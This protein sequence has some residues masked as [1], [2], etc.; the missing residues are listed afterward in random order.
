MSICESGLD[1]KV[2]SRSITIEVKENHPLVHLAQEIPWRLLFALVFP[3]L[4]KTAKGMFWTGRKLYVRTHIA[5]YLLQKMTD[6]KDRQMEW[7]LRDNAAYQIFCGAEIVG[8]WH[9]PDHTKIEEFRSRLSPETQK[10]IANLMAKNG[11]ILG[12]GDP[13]KM[14]VDSTI[15]EANLSYPSDANLL[16]KLSVMGSKVYKYLI[17]K[18][19]NEKSDFDLKG[20]K[21]KARAYFFSL[22]KK[23]EEK[24]MRFEA[25]YWS[26][27]FQIIKV[28][29]LSITTVCL[30]GMPWNIRRAATQIMEH[31]KKFLADAK[32]FVDTGKRISSK[33]LSFHLKEIVCF[34]KGKAGKGLQFGRNIQLGRIGGNF[35]IV[36]GSTS[37]R[38]EDKSS[39]KPMIVEHQRLFGEETLESF[40]TDKGYYKKANQDYLDSL[41]SL[42][43]SALQKPGMDPLSLPEVERET[44][45]KL[46]DRRA[47]IEPLIGHIKQ[48][49]QLGRSR[50]KTDQTTLA[51]GYG[52]VAGFNLRQT[53]RHQI[54]K[55]I[56]AM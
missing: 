53:M 16:V 1:S 12:F 2:E 40:G 7:D 51:A 9:V 14:D 37:I 20:I 31:G 43:E 29:E 56:K 46:S 33:V 38:M 22:N 25:L 35:M 48:G 18:F 27:Y 55:K 17:K 5:V 6:K 19:Y 52:A 26:A 15:Q 21:A 54:G 32:V 30:E 42:K 28:T 49:G 47:G 41:P 45:I 4:K 44:L 36:G 10:E 24:Q 39:V 13:T 50:M 34:N 11:V 8:K 23:I 3:D